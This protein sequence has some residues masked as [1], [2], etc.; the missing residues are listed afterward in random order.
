M[1]RNLKAEMARKNVKGKDIA[2]VLGLRVATVYDKINGHSNFTFNEAQQI[3]RRFFPEYD[4]EY[5]FCSEED[6]SA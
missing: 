5:L 2:N 3:K 4:I 1:L 6:K